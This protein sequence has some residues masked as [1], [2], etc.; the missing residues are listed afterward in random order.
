M[1]TPLQE[2]NYLNK[3]SNRTLRILAVIAIFAVAGSYVLGYNTGKKGF[4]F[5]PKEFKIINQAD[6]PKTVDY[7]LLWDAIDTIN[8][9]YIDKPVDQQ[10]I[11]YGAVKGAIDAVGDPY[12][13]FFQPSELESF[14]TD[15]KG[16]FDGIGAEVGMSGGNVVVVAPLDDSPAARAGL[17]AKDAIVQVNGESTA[18]WS[19]EQAVNKIRGPKGTEVTLTIYREG[20]TK[21]FDV[22][23]V[24]DEIVV[25]SVK[26]EYKNVSV[27]GQNKKIAVVT[28]SQFG[29]DTKSLFSSA[30]NDILRQNVN[31]IVLDLR[32]DPGGYLQ[33]A[34][35]IASNWIPEGQVV[36]TED[37]SEGMPQ[38]YNAEG[39]NRLNGIK[40]VVLING[41]SASAA[42]ILAGA[43]HDYNI[44][45]LVGEKS[46]GKGSV[47]ELVDLAS[48]AAV[49]VTVAKW[50]TP[51]GKNLNK[52][53]LNPDVEVK[54]TEDDINNN[55]DPQM[56]K[57]LQEVTR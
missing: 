16:S 47:Q 43:L 54:M 25:K 40:T 42:E 17:L 29:D 48:G 9:K 56:D 32:N 15:L 23:I 8:Q 18:G 22:K 2:Q 28:L 34:V 5:Q 30:V 39:N 53:G 49:K 44:G 21:P 35:D 10:K 45:E 26:W 24:R 7:Q 51:D 36:V 55:R 19:V 1:E 46:F 52:D 38:K 3:S 14:K 20:K 12:T 57:A 11:L 33:T 50:I 31:G 27:N 37:R 4:I 6:A 13:V 41:G